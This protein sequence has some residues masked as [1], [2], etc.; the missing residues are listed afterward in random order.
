MLLP[1]YCVCVCVCVGR[2]I[3]VVVA[4]T[5]CE[6]FEPSGILWTPNGACVYASIFPV[7]ETLV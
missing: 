4:A 5:E 6:C 7:Y 2:C 1:T 3:V